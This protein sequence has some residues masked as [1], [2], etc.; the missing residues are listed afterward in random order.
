LEIVGG[1]VTLSR[2]IGLS[3]NLRH[4][5]LQERHYADENLINISSC[6][7]LIHLNISPN[8]YLT[9]KYIEYVAHGYHKLVFL[10][11]SYCEKMTDI[12][13]ILHECKPAVTKDEGF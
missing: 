10:D 9:E 6:K 2:L 8:I 12:L 4:F 13:N 1:G 11:V 5:N 3:T 7:S